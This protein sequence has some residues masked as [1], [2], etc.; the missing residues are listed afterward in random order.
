[1]LKLLAASYYM[2]YF[3]KQ[4][5]AVCA[6]RASGDAEELVIKMHAASFFKNSGWCVTEIIKT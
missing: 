2:A 5:F 6:L 4:Q 3:C 1:M